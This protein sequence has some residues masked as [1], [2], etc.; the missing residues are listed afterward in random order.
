LQIL[1]G[2]SF[3]AVDL[4]IHVSA[5]PGAQMLFSN[6]SDD[7]GSSSAVSSLIA[8]DHASVMIVSPGRKSKWLALC[9]TSSAL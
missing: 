9:V 4:Q 1:Q 6:G 5:W 8:I 7:L 3:L 2:V